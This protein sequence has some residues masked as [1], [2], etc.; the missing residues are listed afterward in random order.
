M[1]TQSYQA[2]Q[3]EQAEQSKVEPPLA[4]PNRATRQHFGWA[5][6]ATAAIA[7]GAGLTALVVGV[8]GGTDTDLALAS[9]A[10]TGTSCR[11]RA[12]TS[13]VPATWPRSDLQCRARASTSGSTTWPRNGPPDSDWREV[14]DEK[15]THMPGRSIG[16]TALVSGGCSSAGTAD[17]PK[18]AP[19]TSPASPT[20]SH[21]PGL[22]L[23]AIG[24]SIPYNS[25]GTTIAAPDSSTGTPR[26]SRSHRSRG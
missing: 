26:R 3:A 14:T 18:S 6:T 2:E 17:S 25:E 13:G 21:E 12:W 20:E 22:S 19:S 11:P 10:R 9:P 4:T 5:A 23:V 8:T 16:V 7:I 1:N 24:D 15:A